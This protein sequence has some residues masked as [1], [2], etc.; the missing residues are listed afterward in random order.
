MTPYPNSA[1]WLLY[2]GQW[3][4]QVSDLARQYTTASDW[5]SANFWTAKLYIQL[6]F[7][8]SRA[9][10]FN[11]TKLFCAS[12]FK[13][14]QS[15]IVFST[16]GC[17]LCRYN[18]TQPFTLVTIKLLWQKSSD[19]VSYEIFSL[20]HSRMALWRSSIESSI[21]LNLLRWCY[22]FPPIF[23]LGNLSLSLSLPSQI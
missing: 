22:N 11:I 2:Q 4:Y 6:F 15:C 17:E 20:S 13:T 14:V 3:Q 8:L 7:S 9:A 18:V 5:L 16:H 21:S 19:L 12:F 23:L 10:E 1:T